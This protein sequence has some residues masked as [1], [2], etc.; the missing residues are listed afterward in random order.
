MVPFFFFFSLK[1]RSE[2]PRSVFEV[3]NITYL[4]RKNIGTSISPFFPVFRNRPR[5]RGPCLPL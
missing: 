5:I 3:L 4:I 1:I 2:L